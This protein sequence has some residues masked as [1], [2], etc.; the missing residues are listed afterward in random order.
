MEKVLA[1]LS[2]NGMIVDSPE[3]DLTPTK[4]GSLVS[5]LYIDPWSAVIMLEN[6]A[7]KGGW[8]EKNG[9]LQ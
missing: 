4:L 7:E 8:E 9:K 5:K 3:G 6:L 1:F 2:D